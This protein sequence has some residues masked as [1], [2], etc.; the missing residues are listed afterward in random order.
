MKI[1]AFII[2]SV[3]FITSSWAATISRTEIVDLFSQAKEIFRQADKTTASDP[4]KAKDLYLKSAM[5]F[6]RIVKEGSSITLSVLRGREQVKK[7]IVP[8][9]AATSGT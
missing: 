7:D 2:L 8:A 5:R 4:E 6:E 3:I 1:L 9:E